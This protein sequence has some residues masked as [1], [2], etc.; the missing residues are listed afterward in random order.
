MLPFIDHN[1][2]STLNDWLVPMFCIVHAVLLL[3]D[4]TAASVQLCV[5]QMA[6]CS[7][8]L[9]ERWAFGKS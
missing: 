2:L 7:I 1:G 8:F 3:E 9:T 4:T 6:V 5:Q